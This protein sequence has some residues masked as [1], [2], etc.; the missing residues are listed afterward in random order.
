VAALGVAGLSACTG[1]SDGTP[2]SGGIKGEITYAFWNRTQ[3]PAIRQQAAEFERQHP[4][5]TVNLDL[6]PFGTYWTKLQTE[7]QSGTLPDVFWMNND[8]LNLYAANG[9]LAVSPTSVDLKAFNKSVVDSYQY[10]GKQYGVPDFQS[11]LGVW[12]NKAILE[13]AGVAVPKEGWTWQE[14]QD[15]ALKVSD[16]LKA[17]GIYGVADDA[18]DGYSTYFATIMQAG[19]TAISADGKTSGFDTPAGIAGLKFWSDLIANGSSP[20]MQQLSDTADIDW[21]LSG[22]AAFFWGISSYADKM[23]TSDIAGDIDVAPLPVGKEAAN[24]VGGLALATRAKP[25]NAATA[26]A[27]VEYLTSEKAQSLLSAYTWPARLGA[28]QQQ[29]QDKYAFNTQVFIDAQKIAKQPYPNLQNTEAWQEAVQA[30][31]PDLLSGARPVDTVAKEI[32]D[33]VN[34]VLAE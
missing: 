16:T 8:Y 28:P 12:Y 1:Q 34:A 13:K 27:F 10:D 7:G 23:S 22:K 30:L 29:W 17:D 31:M 32:S 9:L 26:Q 2:S 33:K 5:V 24:P 19:G 21:F 20:D 3:L 6:T 18:T 4:G 14:F 15:D 25:K 11:A